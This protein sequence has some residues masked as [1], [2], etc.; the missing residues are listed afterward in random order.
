[1]LIV[2]FGLFASALGVLL[3]V[4]VGGLVSR[5]HPKESR[6]TWPR[7]LRRAAL[8]WL[9]LLLISAVVAVNC[10]RDAFDAFEVAQS[11]LSSG[12]KQEALAQVIVS[13]M[14]RFTLGAL[15]AIPGP[16]LALGL[17]AFVELRSKRAEGVE[18]G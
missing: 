6:L 4:G 1:M 11:T 3:L 9:G 15:V 14:E 16:S 18:R 17:S 7:L 5:R 8:G 13:V 10:I 12:A 2:T